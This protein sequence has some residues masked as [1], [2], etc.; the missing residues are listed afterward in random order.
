[1]VAERMLRAKPMVQLNPAGSCGSCFRGGWAG[2]QCLWCAGACG[3]SG[4]LV[5]SPRASGKLRT[6]SAL[7]F[8]CHYCRW[9]FSC[10]QAA[11]WIS[12]EAAPPCQGEQWGNG[13][14][15]FVWAAQRWWCTWLVA[16]KVKIKDFLPSS[17]PIFKPILC[18]C[19]YV[20]AQVS[21]LLPAWAQGSILH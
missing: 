15:L 4:I 16:R 8:S 12:S 7:D 14:C 1:M 11:V 18:V 17:L 21:V 20:S 9:Y 3:A 19:M 5:G 2:A 13:W 10:F 6:G